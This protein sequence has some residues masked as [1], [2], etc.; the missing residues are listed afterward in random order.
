MVKDVQKKLNEAVQLINHK[1]NQS[2]NKLNSFSN[3]DL[4]SSKNLQSHLDSLVNQLRK[5]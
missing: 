1:L 3:A 2:R 4:Q 5:K